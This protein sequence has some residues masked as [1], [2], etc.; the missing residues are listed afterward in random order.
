[1]ELFEQTATKK[2][3]PGRNE[4]GEEGAMADSGKE[5]DNTVE[6]GTKQEDS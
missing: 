5:K 6:E 3:A 2:T 4:T 1:M